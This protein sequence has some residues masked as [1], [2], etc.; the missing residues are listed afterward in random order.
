MEKRKELLIL[1]ITT[2]AVRRTK[3]KKKNGT[4]SV[5]NSVTVDSI[6]TTAGGC[7]SYTVPY[8]E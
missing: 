6:H 3:G 4:F 8:Y 5:I 1:P 7:N 2:A